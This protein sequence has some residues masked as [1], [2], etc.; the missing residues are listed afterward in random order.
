[1]KSN[2]KGICRLGIVPVRA[3]S[4]DQSEMVSQL[5]FGDHYSI[6]ELSDD[7]QWAKITIEFD[8]YE[9]W[10]D[11]KQ[12]TEISKDYFDHLNNTEFKI[13][14]DITSTI[15]YKK[16]LIQIVIGSVLPISS[17]ELFEVNEQFAFNGVSKNIGEKQGFD[18]L[19]HIITNYMNAPYLWGGKTPFGI[20]CSGF[21][22]Q[23]FKLC[24][25][26]LKRD[27][28]E[29]HQQGI[30]VDELAAAQPGDLAFFRKDKNNISH[31]GIIMEDQ[32]IIH[33]SG[34]VRKDKLDENGIFNMELS[35]YTHTLDGIKR[36]LKT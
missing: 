16:R 15:L 30:N 27:A 1:M 34:Y 33:T 18:F 10:I 14:T 22:Q 7:G 26:K 25:Y 3:R 36:I 2:S 4:N 5:I 24:G 19:K 13:S 29:Q 21:T 20:D 28:H 8:Q 9:G 35:T 23:I 17:Y 31:V 32:D 12:H 6:N 11:V